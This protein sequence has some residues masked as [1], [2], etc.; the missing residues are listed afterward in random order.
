[1]GVPETRV[2]N[3]HP[4]VAKTVESL[5]LQERTKWAM[6]IHDGLTQS[7][8]SAVLELQTLRHRIEL[9]PEE[10][11]D[12][13]AEV[14][15][16]IRA[17]LHEIREILFELH[18]GERVSEPPLAAFVNEVV[19]RWKLPARVAVEGDLELIPANV[20]D[21]AHGILAESLANAAKHSGSADVTVKLHAG[22]DELRIEV[23]DRGRGI[24]VVNGDDDHFGLRQMRERVEM[25]R[26]S[27]E[28]ES[29]PGRGT[30]VIACLPVG[31][32]SE[33]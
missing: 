3:A 1:V 22:H 20:R 5:M 15:A 31:E 19:E 11:A 2:R 28:I 18:E 12:G 9:D 27:L 8:T 23:E 10:A 13:I 17:D 25:I 30:R 6:R 7:V 4:A 16:A 21:V 32:V 29:T 24:G 33:G 26:G 14:E